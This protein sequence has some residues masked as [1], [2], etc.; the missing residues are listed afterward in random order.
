MSHHKRSSSARVST[1]WAL[2]LPNALS[3]LGHLLP[4]ALCSQ[5]ELMVI[6][7]NFNVLYLPC[8]DL[9]L[10]RNPSMTAGFYLGCFADAPDGGR[11]M[12]FAAVSDDM[13]AQVRKN[14]CVARAP[15][16]F[17]WRAPRSWLAWYT[18]SKAVSV[19]RRVLT[20]RY[21]CIHKCLLVAKETST[22][23]RGRGAK[24]HQENN[25]S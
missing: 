18:A 9:C 8:G 22:R 10:D 3:S 17:L 16:Q 4:S 7:N 20:T 25:H 11:V 19:C 13:D 15:E 24:P 12:D 2:T 6:T 14:S 5:G 1:S 21:T 23:A